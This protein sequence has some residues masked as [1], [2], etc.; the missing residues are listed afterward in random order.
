[1]KAFEKTKSLVYSLL[2]KS[3][4]YTQT[5]MIYLAK[6]GFW[7][8]LGQII[9]TA[10]SFLLAIAFANLLDPVT[11]GNYKY[12]LSLA[13]ILSIS[14]LIGMRT[15]ITQ[16]TARGFEGSFYSGFKE[17]LKFGVL[18]SIIAIGLA[19]YYFL[20]G[21]YILPIPLLLTAIFLPITHASGVY[22]SFLLGKKLF[23]VQVKYNTLTKVIS[24]LSL[25]LTLFLTKNLFWLIAVYFISNAFLNYFFYLI[26]RKKN[27][28]NKKEH[29]E[30]L[31]YGK[32]LSLMT[33]ISGVANHLD[34]IFLFTL[35]GSGQLAIYSFAMLVPNQII[36]ILKN[37]NVLALPKFSIKSKQ[38]IKTTLIQKFWK[39]LFLIAT[40]I[41][42][43]I[44]LA[45]YFYKIFFPQ[46]LASV[47]YSQLLIFSLIGYSSILF[48]TSFEAKVKKKELYLLQ[49]LPSFV[50]ILFLIFL[51]PI[52]GIWGVVATVVITKIFTLILSLILFRKI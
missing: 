6:G 33:V 47:P 50:R 30:T 11:Y 24:T 48:T 39:L 29:P 2:K 38:E 19:G 23:N 37:I 52:F 12:V 10:A 14:T 32:H 21:N 8:T 17:K 46:Y 42:A 35:M 36:S 15:A 44:I 49:T 31:S 18:G 25:I 5:D 26:T 45:P 9:S 51:I 40:I 27:Q 3:E 1:M 20:R 13:G 41:A 4:R 43:Y 16:A 34:K 7:L 28:P 22:G